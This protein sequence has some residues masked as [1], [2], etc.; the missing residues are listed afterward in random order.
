MPVPVHEF[1]ITVARTARYLVRGEETTSTGRCWYALH[2]YAQL[3][4]EVS[5]AASPLIAAGG[6]LVAPE[7]LSRFYRDPHDAERTPAAVGASWMT[8]EARGGEIRD[9]IAY[10]DAVHTAVGSP[11]HAAVLGF[12]QGAATAARWAT[13]GAVRPRL[14]VL[15][16]GIEPDDLDEAARARLVAM[17]VVYVHG[18]FDRLLDHAVPRRRADALRTAGGDADVVTFPGGHRLDPGVLSRLAEF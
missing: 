12:S 3:A 17:R 11:A 7:A 16:G 13:L 15:W 4:H 18:D 2:G 8:R 9:Y 14:L 6:R 10:L 1:E 5:E